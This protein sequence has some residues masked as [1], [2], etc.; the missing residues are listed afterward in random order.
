LFSAISLCERRCKRAQIHGTPS[1]TSVHAATVAST[2]P[3]K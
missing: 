1:D 3:A 2:A